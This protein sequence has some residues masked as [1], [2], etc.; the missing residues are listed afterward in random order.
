MHLKA[1]LGVE[2]DKKLPKG[3]TNNAVVAELSEAIKV[4][5]KGILIKDIS[6]QVDTAKMSE[7]ISAITDRRAEELMAETEVGMPDIKKIA[8]AILNAAIDN[9]AKSLFNK[10]KPIPEKE[11]EKL[12]ESLLATFGDASALKSALGLKPNSELPNNL[13]KLDEIK[14]AASF[15]NVKVGGIPPLYARVSVQGINAKEVAGRISETVPLSKCKRELDIGP[16]ESDIAHESFVHQMK[17][18]ENKG[19]STEMQV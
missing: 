19:H 2:P 14:D 17:N 10:K 9:N 13:E 7:K 5:S 12:S 6:A 1:L 18:R 4:T 15:C 8:A 3:L 16:K 11:I